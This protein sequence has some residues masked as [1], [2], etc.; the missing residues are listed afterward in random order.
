[1]H[2]VLVFSWQVHVVDENLKR[3]VWIIKS[4][5]ENKV[6]TDA[7][8]KIFSFFGAVNKSLPVLN[9]VLD[10]AVQLWRCTGV[11]EH[12]ATQNIPL[13]VYVKSRDY[14]NLRVSN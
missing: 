14:V 5:F 4:L 12:Q 11:A 3:N 10:E 9:I 6:A 8:L 2:V 13:F 7:N 1:M